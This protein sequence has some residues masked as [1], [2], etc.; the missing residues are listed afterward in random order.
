MGWGVGKSGFLAVSNLINERFCEPVFFHWQSQWLDCGYFIKE[1]PK[2]GLCLIIISRA[3]NCIREVFF[4]EPGIWFYRI[5][6]LSFAFWNWIN[7]KF[8]LLGQIPN[9]AADFHI[10]V[11]SGRLQPFI[12]FVSEMRDICFVVFLLLPL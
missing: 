10:K 3:D 12:K 8:T 7:I 6:D 9:I 4:G 1:Q 5:P 11:Y 2:K